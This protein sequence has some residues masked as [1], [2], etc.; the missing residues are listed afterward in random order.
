MANDQQNYLIILFNSTVSLPI[1][2]AI[3]L[4]DTFPFWI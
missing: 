2:L 3:K 4:L 1:L